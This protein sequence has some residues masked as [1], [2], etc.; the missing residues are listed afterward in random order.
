MPRYEMSASFAV[1][2][3]THFW[4]DFVQRQFAR[5]Q[6]RIGTGDLYIVIDESIEPASA[7]DYDRIIRIRPASFA[8]LNL[9]EVTTGGSVVWYNIDYPNHI[10]FS[11]IKKYDFYVSVEY[12]AV[13]TLDIER[14]VNDLAGAGIDYLGLPIKKPASDWPWYKQHLDIYGQNMLVYLSCFSV[15][16][17]RA[18]ARLLERRQEMSDEFKNGTLRFWPNNEAFIPNEIRAA[19]MALD[20]L[21]HF[22]DTGKY[23]WWPPM[24]EAELASVEGGGFIH[25]VLSGQRYAKSIVHH[26]P[27]FAALIM[28]N[29]PVRAKLRNLDNGRYNSVFLPEIRRRLR[30]HLNRILEQSGL[31]KAWFSTALS[32]T[33]LKP[34]SK[35]LHNSAD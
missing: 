8:A 3:K 15:F 12:D 30:D 17:Y 16:S 25:P 26:E 27:S 18:M 14:L 32:G 21:S 13:V 2:F 28:P 19:G 34:Q 10:A 22:G 7:F 5:L 33:T 23:D 31:R 6:A 9:A 1:L 35:P 20:T 4:D 29:S 11:A 24:E